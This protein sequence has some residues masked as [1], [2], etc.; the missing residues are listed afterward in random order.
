MAA[1]MTI[2]TTIWKNIT[3][4]IKNNVMIT[5]WA[6][7]GEAVIAAMIMVKDRHLENI[8]IVVTLGGIQLGWIHGRDLCMILIDQSY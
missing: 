1:L 6:I 7:I 5:Q 2:I 8:E 3:T 4:L